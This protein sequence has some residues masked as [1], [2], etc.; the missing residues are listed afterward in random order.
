LPL[1]SHFFQATFPQPQPLHPA[2]WNPVP[3]KNDK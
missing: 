3:T 2:L 1:T